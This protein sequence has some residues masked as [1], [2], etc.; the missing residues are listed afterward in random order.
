MSKIK[1]YKSGELFQVEDLAPMKI[2]RS[3]GAGRMQL[4]DPVIS[5]THLEVTVNNKLEKH[6]PV[7]LQNGDR[8]KLGRTG[9]FE[10]EFEIESGGVAAPKAP[11]P[12]VAEEPSAPEPAPLM[13]HLLRGD[14]P[15]WS[16]GEIDVRVADIIEETSTA[17]TIRLVG[18]K[19]SM[20]FSYDPGQF[21]TLLLEIN[22]EKV[23]R[24]YSLS[25]TPSRPHCIELT[26]KRVPGGLVSNWVADEL[27]LGDV[28]KLRGPS[29]R[30]TCFEYPTDKLFFIGAGSG[31]T[32]LMSMTRWILDTA[33]DADLKFFV[34]SQTPSEI[35][36]CRELE[37]LSARHRAFQCLVT[38]TSGASGTECWLGQTGRVNGQMLELFVPDLRDRHVFTCGPAPFMDAV[39][40]SLE[41]IG[42]DMG[43]FHQESFGGNRVATGTI[44]G[45]RDAV[46]RSSLDIP[47]PIFGEDAKPAVSYDVVFAESNKTIATTGEASLLEVAEANG[48]D[49]KYACRMGAC[50][51]C[52]VHCSDP[53]AVK[54]PDSA[55]VSKKDRAAGYIHACVTK[56][57]GN[58]QIKA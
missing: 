48:V 55:N 27:K 22:G 50:G 16:D 26:I 41:A 49:I 42:F 43:Q 31:I 47:L 58:C 44:V 23:E 32:P 3:P 5:G 30:F 46:T 2:G 12:S 45:P 20:M 51:A 14:I 56:P 25:S 54:M 17:R 38:V 28:L 9:S 57:I 37:Y 19:E 52:K 34:S 53:E 4:E 6:V 33:A 36:F 35:I 40:K 15:V 18:A 10:L 21:V 29:G 11:E 8:V 1:V 39:E 24:S 7:E 13:E